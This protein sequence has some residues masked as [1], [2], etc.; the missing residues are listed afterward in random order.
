L[1]DS[2]LALLDTLAGPGRTPSKSVARREAIDAVHASLAELPEHYRAALW[3]VHIKGLSVKAAATDM[4][5]S[6]RAIHGLC[7]RGL[8]LLRNRLRSTTTFLSST[9]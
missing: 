2:T 9:G 6:E 1:E 4:G 8:R 7:R 3:L 5:R